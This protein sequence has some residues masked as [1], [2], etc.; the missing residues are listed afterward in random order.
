MASP[1][2]HDAIVTGRVFCLPDWR[3]ADA[4]VDLALYSP[5]A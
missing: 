1:L 5:F 4:R 2:L 3:H